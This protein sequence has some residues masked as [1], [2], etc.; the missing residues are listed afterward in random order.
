[1]CGEGEVH[2]ILREFPLVDRLNLCRQIV[3]YEFQY[4][5]I[6]NCLLRSA[7]PEVR[8]YYLRR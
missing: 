4:R 7:N 8:R 6:H 5:V 3:H 2:E 1:M